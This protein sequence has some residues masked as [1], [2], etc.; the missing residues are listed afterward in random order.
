MATPV[1]PC[2]GPSSLDLINALG[3]LSFD[4]TKALLIYLGVKLKDVDD[5]TAGENDVR[6]RKVRC[7]HKW[8]DMDPDASW[9]NVVSALNKIGKKTLAVE[10]ENT[11][12]LGI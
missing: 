6:M 9:E 7:F 4:E 3:Q 11:H 5:I 12:V 10:I 8:L 1:S 2:R